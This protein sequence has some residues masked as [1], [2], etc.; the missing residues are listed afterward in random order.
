MTNNKADDQQI[1]AQDNE[2]PQNEPFYL[3][4]IYFLSISKSLEEFHSLLG[5][6]IFD[7]PN[8][9]EP[10]LKMLSELLSKPFKRKRGPKSKDNRLFEIKHRYIVAPDES[11]VFI[12]RVD[13][14]KEI[15]DQ[16]GMNA[17][18]AAKLYDQAVGP[19][20]KKGNN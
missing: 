15:A 11:G 7:V 13:A 10:E 5:K 20:R 4:D 14:I 8:Y 17:E 19:R 12:K 3:P 16:Y 9:N 1:Q 2:Y 18:A 6:M